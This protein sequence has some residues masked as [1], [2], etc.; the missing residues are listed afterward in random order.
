MEC[1]K[2]TEINSIHVFPCGSMFLRSRITR[3]VC[4]PVHISLGMCVS[5]MKVLVI[6]VCFVYL[7]MITGQEAQLI[8]PGKR[9]I[10]KCSS[11]I[12]NDLISFTVVC[13]Q[14]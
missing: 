1:T 11:A 9:K 13:D 3:D 12:Y 5:L 4:F 2:G 8:C 6:Y 14:I 10:Y 7:F